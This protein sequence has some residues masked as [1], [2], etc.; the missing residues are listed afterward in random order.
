M[1]PLPLEVLQLNLSP[2]RGRVVYPG[3]LS[4]YLD[5]CVAGVVFSKWSHQVSLPLTD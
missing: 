4:Q 1:K 3:A 5:C 2:R